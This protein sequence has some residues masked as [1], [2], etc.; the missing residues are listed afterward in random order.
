MNKLREFLKRMGLAPMVNRMRDVLSIMGFD[1]RLGTHDRDILEGIIF[2]YLVESDEYKKI[3]FIGT[4]YYTK[5]YCKIFKNKVFYTL[6]YDRKQAVFGCKL[7]II[8]SFT[9]ISSHFKESEVDVVICNGVYG[10][11]LNNEQDVNRAFQST[12]KVLRKGGVFIFG[13]SN[14]KEHS[15]YD[16][17]NTQALK[18][19]QNFYFKPLK[20]DRY[21][22]HTNLN[23]TF[24]FLVK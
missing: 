3:V 9:E 15:P 12:Y 24:R 22:S 14:C 21:E 1:L 11:G 17:E 10:Y 4:A 8:D 20:T 5:G 2:P 6:E 23:V 18:L 7:H 19:F 16:V 13:W